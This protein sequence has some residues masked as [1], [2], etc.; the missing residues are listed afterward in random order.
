MKLSKFLKETDAKF[1]IHKIV[2]KQA[3]AQLKSLMQE[4]IIK[5]V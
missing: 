2:F 5:E 4:E 3:K 1:K